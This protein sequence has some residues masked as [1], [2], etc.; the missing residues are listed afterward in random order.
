MQEYNPCSNDA[1]INAFISPQSPFPG[2]IEAIEVLLQNQGTAALTSVNINWS[3]NDENQTAFEWTGNL[4]SG[5]NQEVNIG[6]YDFQAGILYRLKV[7][8]SLPNN[9]NDC[10]HYNDTILSPELSGPLCGI[11]T[12]GGN[13][14]DFTSFVDAAEVLN[15]A[16]ITCQVIFNVRDGIYYEQFELGEIPGSS[17]ENTI[18]FQSE[19]GDSTQA[20]IHIKPEAL[21]NEPMIHLKASENIIFKNLG[22]FTGSTNGEANNAIH[23]ESAN[24]I[25]VENCLI[26]THNEFDFGIEIIGGSRALGA[27]S[28]EIAERIQAEG[29]K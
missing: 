19:E 12:I 13:N 7:W 25:V 8:T 10:N 1:G 26:E 22:L 15:S 18:T 20:I 27:L 9:T 2:G 4:T 6:N 28:I 17:E 23:I 14:P 3:V 29:G 11:Y 21:F 24:N 16:G 5:S